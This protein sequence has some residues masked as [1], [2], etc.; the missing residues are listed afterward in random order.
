MNTFTTA[1]WDQLVK[2]PPAT[3]AQQINSSEEVLVSLHE[4]GTAAI[5]ASLKLE[6]TLRD[7]LKKKQCFMQETVARADFMTK[8][9]KM[10]AISSLRNEIKHFE[11]LTDINAKFLREHLIARGDTEYYLNLLHKR[12][13]LQKKYV[14]K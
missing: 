3:Y 7:E 10:A 8:K 12:L 11:Q 13:R 5:S 4:A 14:R 1:V 2:S 9:A 6:G